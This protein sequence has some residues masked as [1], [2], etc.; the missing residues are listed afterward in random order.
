[1][2]ELLEHIPLYPLAPLLFLIAVTLF[3]LQ[4]ARH[5]RVFAVAQPA[6]VTDQPDS[7]L[8]SMVRFALVQVR[9]FRDPTA[10]L[11]HAAIFWGFVILT[12]GTVDRLLFGSTVEP[13]VRRAH[14]PVLTVR[15]MAPAAR[16]AA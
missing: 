2:S 15:P 8:G 10:G 1:M 5:L 7:R 9:M 3:A 6:V 16:A 13:V 14:C 11:M 4:M 12:I